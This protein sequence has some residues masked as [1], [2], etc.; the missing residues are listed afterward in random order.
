MKP[1][2]HLHTLLSETP[3]EARLREGAAFGEALAGFRGILLFGCGHL[4]RKLARVL[5]E[6]R[7]PLLGFVDN[8]QAKWGTRVDGLEVFPPEEACRRFGDTAAFLVTI[9]APRHRFLHTRAQLERLGARRVLPFALALWAHPEAL[10]HYQFERPSVLLEQAQEIRRACGLWGDEE[11]RRQYV[12]HLAWRLRL[13]FEGLPNPEPETQ[14]F[15]DALM[16]ELPGGLFVDGGA[17][18]G[19]TLQ[20]MLA[21][22][23]RSFSRYVA[24]EPDPA[25]FS[26][27]QAFHAG[28]E[29]GLRARVSLVQAALS[30]QSGM[31]RFDAA[32]ATRAA[33]SD[34]G[35]LEVQTLALDAWLDGSNLTCIKLDLEGAERSALEGARNLI[36]QKAPDLAVCVYHRPSDLW[37]LPLLLQTWQPK[38][39]FHLRTHDEDG[40]ELVSYATARI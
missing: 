10:P 5:R 40:L 13:D 6:A 16:P 20:R 1:A 26:R 25:N 4:G 9:W 31:A 11:S 21:C 22:G 32:G 24:I 19:D 28:L 35:G 29:E 2:E 15:I 34:A 38:Y 39:R 37:E 27:L 14:Y 12:A 36:S 8:A 7:R 18:D 30:E 23:R 33:L 3:A 17:F